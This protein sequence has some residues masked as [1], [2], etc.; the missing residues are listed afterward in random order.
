MAIGTQNIGMTES[1]LTAAQR[2]APRAGELAEQTERERALPTEL[3]G[4]LL[5]AGLLSLCLPRALGGR[6]AQPGEM[7]LALEALAR[8]DGA[9]AWCAMIA[10]TSSLLG[11]YLPEGDAELVFARGSNVTG[12]VFAPRGR[13]ERRDGAYVV[14]GRWSFASGVQHCDW[15]LAG[16]VVHEGEEPALLENGAPD[17]RLMMMPADSV[18]VIDTWSVSGLRGTGSHDMTV[19]S[20][21]VPASRAVS[22]PGAPPLHPGALY[23]FPLFGLLAMGIAAVALGVARGAVDDFLALAGAKTPA[24]GRR[25]LAERSTVQ[26]ELARAEAKLRA[27]RGLVLDEAERAWQVAQT[28]APIPEQNRV[29][30]RMAASQ[31][32]EVA[33]EVT[34]AMYHAAGG[35]SIYDSSPLQRRFRDVHVATQHVMVA[36]ATWELTG[37]LLL[38]L[39]TDTTQL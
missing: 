24:G 18:E 22:L 27:A 28:G 7:V 20:Q 25:T 3:V 4:D 17:V 16:C 15:V 29:G 21:V 5:D 31:A 9:C 12:G 26:A 39:K 30:V 1:P 2:I 19:L 14:S 6:E 38:G 33:A 8:G 11:A 10:S 23:A 13:A 34:T 37:R 35:S 32:T 36:P